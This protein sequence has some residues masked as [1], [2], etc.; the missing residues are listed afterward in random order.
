[1]KTSRSK[2]LFRGEG[3][4]GMVSSDSRGDRAQD[5]MGYHLQFKEPAEGGSP[6]YMPIKKGADLPLL[7]IFVGVGVGLMAFGLIGIFVGTVVLAVAHK[8][9]SAWVDEELTEVGS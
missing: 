6:Y 3:L 5:R 2:R 1:V 8:L 7:L 9:L 4:K